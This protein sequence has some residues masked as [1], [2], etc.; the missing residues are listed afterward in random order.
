MKRL[1]ISL[2][3]SAP[4]LLAA[5]VYANPSTQ[6]Y[7]PELRTDNTHLSGTL[8][9][10][11]ASYAYWHRHGHRWHRGHWHQWHHKH[12]HHHYHYYRR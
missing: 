3:I 8:P 12:Y 6:L 2:I 11:G 5:P 1:I 10:V 4:L 7:N 9:K